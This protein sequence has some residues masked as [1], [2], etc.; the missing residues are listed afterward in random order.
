M[1]GD[2][3]QGS[4]LQHAPS[5]EG[6]PSDGPSGQGTLRLRPFAALRP[7]VELAAQ[8]A[9]S[10]YDVLSP[11]EA[12]MLARSNELS[13][14]HVTRAEV[15]LP[16]GIDPHDDAVYVAAKAA[17]ERFCE[18]GVL[19]RDPTPNLYAYRQQVV[20]AGRK[21]S[22]VGVVG[23]CHVD[24]Y[25]AGVIKRHEVTRRDKE[26]D[27]TRHTLE[28]N[29]NPGPVFLAY[30]PDAR[31]TDLLATATLETPL[32]D[33][34]GAGGVQHTVWAIAE[35]APFIE[36]FAQVP[37][38]YIADGHHRCASAARVAEQRQQR[39]PGHTGDEEYNWFLSVLFAA[40]QL[41]V[42]PYHRLIR[43]LGGLQS[44]EII[45]RLRAIADVRPATSPIQ[46][47]PGAFG[48]YLDGAWLRVELQREL[49]DDADPLASLDY[50]LLSRH[51]LGPIF[52]IV[53][54]RVDTRVEFVGGVRGTTEL[55]RR[56]DTGEH[57]LAFAMRPARID[58]LM[59]VADAGLVM[60]PK[61]TWFE[62]KLC[63]G[64]LIHSLD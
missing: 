33:F 19:M 2:A 61:S 64:L 3:A 34:T 13:F 18:R 44:A 51:V 31:L 63:S 36:R 46:D 41:N 59:R 35:S 26:D 54:L 29:A 62:P 38:A 56:V 57:A 6:R 8:V 48:M 7:R 49:I 16:A 42:L 11:A 5:G 22:Q 24:D 21:V 50:V 23:C 45:E 27:R 40:D 55:E 47:R 60:P 14:L 4:R 37:A 17:F 15:G 20:L 12:I 53:D 1:S 43:D 58:Q 30:R 32:Y 28:I 39:N 9:C 52:G 10:P 25:R